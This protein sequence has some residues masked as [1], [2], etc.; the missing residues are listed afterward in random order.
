MMQRRAFR[1]GTVYMGMGVGC[2]CSVWDLKQTEA[3]RDG[4]MEEWS[5]RNVVVRNHV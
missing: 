3:M 5:K 4:S 1:P 2:G